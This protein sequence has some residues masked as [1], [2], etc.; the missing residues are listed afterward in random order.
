LAQDRGREVFAV[1]PRGN[2]EATRDRRNTSA[3]THKDKMRPGIVR[4]L[5]KEPTPGERASHA[6]KL[7]WQND[8]SA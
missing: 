3:P 1:T 2:A 4:L 8:R 6:A 7:L 5:E